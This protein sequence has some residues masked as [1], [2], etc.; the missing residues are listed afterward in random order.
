MPPTFGDRS[1]PASASAAAASSTKVS[2]GPSEVNW[3]PIGEI[4]AELIQRRANNRRQYFAAESPCRRAGM[5]PGAD[6]VAR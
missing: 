2:D 1:A 3:R 5:P 6:D 4:V